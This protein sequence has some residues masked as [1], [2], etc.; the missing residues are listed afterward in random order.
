MWPLSA[1]H[2]ASSHKISPKSEN[3]SMSYGHKC[4]FQDGGR[5]HLEFQ[6]FKSLVTW[7]RSGSPFAVVYWISSKSDNFSLRYGDLTIFK[8]AAVR[9][10]GFKNLKFLSCG[11]RRRAIVLLRTKFRRHRKISRWV[12]VKKPIFKIAATAIL[13]FKNFN[14]WSRECNPV[15]HLL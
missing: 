7:L 15:H 10:L 8:M 13:N 3:R 5:R 9:H 1:S 4:D 2:S 14:Y 11:P 12:M 6:K